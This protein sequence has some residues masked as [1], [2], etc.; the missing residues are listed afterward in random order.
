[1][2]NPF[3]VGKIITGVTSGANNLVKTF[4]GSKQERDQQSHDKFGNVQNS[5]TAEFN[6]R[7]NRTWW[8]S[9]WDG[10]NRM[11][12][13]VFVTLVVCYFL[14]AYFKP[15]EFQV[16][17]V[18]L[19]TIP[20]AM[21]GI[22]S[23][24]LT[25][26]FGSKHFEIKGKLA[27]SDKEFTV[28]QERIKTL[29]A[30]PSVVDELPPWY[31]VAQSEMETG[32]QEIK[33]KEDN[34]RIVEY[35]KATSLRAPDDETAWCSAFVNWCMMT[36]GVART[37]KAN[38]RSW[39]D[40]GITLTEPREGCVVVFKRGSQAWQGHVGFFI[41]FQGDQVLCLGG[42]QGDEVNISGYSKSRVLGYRWGK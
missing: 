35:H 8:D 10:F 18:A 30:E 11:P 3:S 39:L 21:W 14:M 26:Y 41:G 37:D 4:K 29:R 22:L 32:V 42:N 12:R 17:N 20:L 27:L 24:I 2:W 15:V 38:A 6:T 28:M 33:G 7:V 36:A 13:P 1:M 34:P 5:F 25:F 19:A 23:G 16:L 31:K 40:W 9:L